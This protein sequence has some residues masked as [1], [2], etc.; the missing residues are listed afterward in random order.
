[1]PPF[2]YFR[3]RATNP[4]L[5]SGTSEGEQPTHASFKRR[6]SNPCLLSGTSEGEQPTHASSAVLQESNQRMHTPSEGEQPTHASIF[7]PK[8]TSSRQ[9]AIKKRPGR[10]VAA[11]IENGD[12][13]LLFPRNAGEHLPGCTSSHSTHQL[14][15]KSWT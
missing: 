4:C 15:M 8:L 10:S 13:T 2:R 12:S 11:C 7:G 1:M 3:R 14:L 9:P 6:A 5:L